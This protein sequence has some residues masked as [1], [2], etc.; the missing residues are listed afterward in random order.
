LDK[1]APFCLSHP[2][3]PWRH[4]YPIVSEN[5][6]REFAGF[7]LHQPH[8]N[9]NTLVANLLSAVK[10]QLSQCGLLSRINF[11]PWRWGDSLM[12]ELDT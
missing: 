9:E 11:A 12:A 4:D 8:F 2:A 7:V 1:A 6:S 10:A 3:Q 5:H